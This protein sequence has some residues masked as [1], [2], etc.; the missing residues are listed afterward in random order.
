M[1]NSSAVE[2]SK[3]T[4]RYGE[5]AA[6]DGLDL[7]VNA[8]EIFAVL[9]PNGSGKTTFFRL[10]STLLAPTSGT[11]AIFGHDL[12]SERDTVRKLIGVEFQSPSLDKVLTSEEN[13]RHHGHLYG[14][15]GRALAEKMERM[16]EAVN[17]LDRRHE[18]VGSFSGGM[19]RRVELAKGMLTD[20]RLLILD[21]PSTGLDPAARIDMWAYLTR[22]RKE[23]GVT[24]LL[25]THLM[26]EADRCDRLAVLD[27]GKLLACDSPSALKDRIGGDVITLATK[28]PGAVRVGLKERLGVD[29]DQVREVDGTIRLERARGHE[30]VPQLIE[31]LPGLI[32]SVAVGRPT[33]EDVFIDL[34]GRRLAE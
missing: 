14:L 28:Q 29:G 21:E 18:R 26:D 33:L 24:V 7:T 30:F 17:L 4:R 27:H 1:S 19:R 22:I 8:G 11:A 32:D 6:L 15:R 25:T 9:G 34:T 5:R 23:Q 13:L 20:P 31:A 3:L 2:C 10:L 16:L 12:V